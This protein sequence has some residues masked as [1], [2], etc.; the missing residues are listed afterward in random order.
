M[1]KHTRKAMHMMEK[2]IPAS[3]YRPETPQEWNRLLI[4][5][6]EFGF[7]MYRDLGM[8]REE[9]RRLAK[10]THSGQVGLLLLQSGF[11]D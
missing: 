5:L 4:A 11:R 10:Q 6:E 9:A 1:N 3:G 7:A 2:A 8:S